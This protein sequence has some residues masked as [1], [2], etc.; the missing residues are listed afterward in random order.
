MP[1]RLAATERALAADDGSSARWAWLFALALLLAWIAW[2]GLARV[3]VV[4][5]SRSARL[6]IR[7]PSLGLSALQAGPI[8]RH[9][10]QLGRTVRAGEV[11]AEID[12]PIGDARR[13]EVQAQL[14]ALPARRTALLAEREA[15]AARRTQAGRGHDAGLGAAQ[16]RAE[17]V[18]TQLAL[19][20]DT[21]RRLETAASGGGVSAQ[22]LAR[23]RSERQRLQDAERA[24]HA[25]ADRESASAREHVDELRERLTAIDGRLAAWQ[26]EHDG[27]RAALDRLEAERERRRV[28][29]PDDGVIVE[30]TELGPGTWVAEGQRLA[31][32]LPDGP[33]RL[34]AE[35]DAA[36][37]L[38]RLQPGQTA[39]LR[40]DA[41]PWTEHGRVAARVQRV[42]GEPRN[43]LLRVELALSAATDDAARLALQ[44]GLSGQVEVTLERISPAR[45]VWRRVAG[46]TDTATGGAERVAAAAPTH[47]R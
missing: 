1:A 47:G 18:R 45:L 4:E 11:L 6:E 36:R 2:A 32:L 23:A 31:T 15:V 20:W 29:A 21:E 25:D 17:Q 38:G 19:A 16:A 30:S 12:D 8:A 7:Q 14:D 33:L 40:L 41:R 3:R 35:F 13:R 46:W 24:A 39:E 42:A 37:A 43:G 22:D 44:H 10:L 26:A 5:V 9:S 34:V 28:R 27:L